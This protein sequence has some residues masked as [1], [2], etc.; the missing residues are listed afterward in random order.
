VASKSGNSEGKSTELNFLGSGT[1][2]EGD[3]F[4]KSSIRVDGKIKGTLNC[5]N[6]LTVGESGVI[7]GSVKAKNAVVGGKIQGKIIVEEKLVLETKSQLIGE[8]KSKKL[9]VDEGAVF[10]GA[11]D[12]G[13]QSPKPEV[14]KSPPPAEAE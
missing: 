13:L 4:T 6:T 11:S 9:I 10:D 3:V 5:E 14:K 1:T 7:E 12:M 2:V 8:L